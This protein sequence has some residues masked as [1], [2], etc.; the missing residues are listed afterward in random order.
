[1]IN[2]AV[3]LVGKI[4]NETGEVHLAAPQFRFPRF[5]TT[6]P[7]IGVHGNPE[8][9]ELRLLIWVCPLPLR[10]VLTP[11][12]AALFVQVPA[13]E[14]PST[15]PMSFPIASNWSFDGVP[16]LS[17]PSAYVNLALMPEPKRVSG[18]VSVVLNT[19]ETLAVPK[20]ATL[21]NEHVICEVVPEQVA[22]LR[23]GV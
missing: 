14:V 9:S 11:G 19:I 16:V 18:A 15:I 12:S 10:I 2:V 3:P 1:M 8:R 22:V 17:F 13:S 4:T 5:C 20:P 21:P 7:A 23:V 6:P